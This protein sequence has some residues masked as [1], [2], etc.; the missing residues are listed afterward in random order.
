MK[1]IKK[2][3]IAAAFAGLGLL[4]AS[5]SANLVT[6]GDFEAGNA[7]WNQGNFTAGAFNGFV[8]FGTTAL[9]GGCVGGLCS[10]NQSIATAVGQTYEFSFEYGSDGNLAN[11]FI[12][13]FG[14]VV[15]FHTINDTTDTRPG[16]IHES[17]LVTATSTS[18]VIDFQIRNDPSYQSVDNVSV[19]AVPEPA[20]LALFGLGLAGLG[21]SRRQR[22]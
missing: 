22:K 5:A 3:A 16:Y 7:G 13:L 4:S 6:N 11:E 2:L 17:F 1:F 8:P 14:G 19:T 12:A 10:T 15:V 20:S 18:T 9:Y 21:F